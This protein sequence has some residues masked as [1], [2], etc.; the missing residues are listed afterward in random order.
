MPIVIPEKGYLEAFALVVDINGFTKMVSHSEGNVIADFVRDV[1]LGSI[2]AI[3]TNGGEVVGFMGDAILGVLADADSTFRACAEIAKDLNSQCEYISAAQRGKTE[4][5]GFCNG[6]PALKI[7]VEYGWLDV[8]QIG[9]RKLGSHPLIIGSAINHAAR[10]LSAGDGNRCLIGPQA[11]KNGF[12]NYH[13]EGP[14]TVA[15]KPGELAYEYFQLDLSDIWIEG[16]SRNGLT[17]W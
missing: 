7:G 1:L 3:E 9:S 11:R 13:L 12:E 4:V 2:R 5:W 17:Y 6:G 10:I 15:G 16:G 8:C 14:C